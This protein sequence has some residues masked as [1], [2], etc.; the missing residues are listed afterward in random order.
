MSGV[1]S[2]RPW[3]G[4][5][6]KRG[7][8]RVRAS[9]SCSV[10][11]PTACLGAGL[12]VRPSM[13]A[14]GETGHLYAGEENS[15]S[16]ESP[17]KFHFGQRI[18]FIWFLFIICLSLTIFSI[19][20]DI[21]FLVSFSSLSTVFFSSLSIFKIIDWKSLSPK[22]IVY[23]SS[24][25]FLLISF[26]SLWWTV[27]SCFLQSSKFCVENWISWISWCASLDVRVSLLTRAWCHSFIQIVA[28][29]LI[30]DFSKAFCWPCCLL[31]VV[32]EVSKC[33]EL[34]ENNLLFA[35]VCGCLDIPSTLS[36][37]S[38]NFALACISC[39]HGAWQSTRAEMWAFSDPFST[40]VQLYMVF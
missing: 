29:G 9:A 19:F 8:C 37:P 31:H 23:P 21:I 40:C 33:P 34:R 6:R 5:F 15:E 2:A 10:Q 36:Q 16:P 3:A 17:L 26:F 32:T 28:V 30:S 25:Q 38:Y 14:N 4:G 18:Y 35:A 39:L 27:L 22:S 13:E 20:G 24:G 12:E 7:I 1:S 11:M